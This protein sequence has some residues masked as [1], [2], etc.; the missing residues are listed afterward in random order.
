MVYENVHLKYEV[1]ENAH[2]KYMVYEIVYEI[3][4]LKYMDIFISHFPKPSEVH[5]L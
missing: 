1:H 5:G 2:L 4:H 3:F